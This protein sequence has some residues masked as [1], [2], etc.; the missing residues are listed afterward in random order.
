MKA[1]VLRS[2]GTNCDQESAHALR[3]AGAEP[4]VLHI[5]E[6]IGGHASLDDYKIMII[7]GGFSYGDD[8]AAGKILANELRFKLGDALSRFIKDGRR[9]IGI[10]NGFQ[11]LVKTGFL[12][13]NATRER[14]ASAKRYIGAQ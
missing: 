13:G 1:L 10:C 4:T 14:S 12:P 5:N 11:V 3:L 8:I 7:P 6:F 9:V 2:A